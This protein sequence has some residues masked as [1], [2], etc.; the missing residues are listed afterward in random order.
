MS[1]A[2][3]ADARPSR[4]PPSIDRMANWAALAPL[5]ARAGRPLVIEA[6]RAWAEAKR[7]TEEVAGEAALYFDPESSEELAMQSWPRKTCSP[8]TI[9]PWWSYPG[10]CRSFAQR[11]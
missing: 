3:P 6:L 4:R 10:T 11:R 1:R 7:G 2:D 8:V 5:I 9:E